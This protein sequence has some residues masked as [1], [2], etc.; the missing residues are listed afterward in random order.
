[1]VSH[2]M[3]CVGLPNASQVPAIAS[4]PPELFML[5]VL[6]RRLIMPGRCSRAASCCPSPGRQETA[7]YASQRLATGYG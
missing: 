2:N 3:H 4:G 1:M 7:D 6:Y 5:A